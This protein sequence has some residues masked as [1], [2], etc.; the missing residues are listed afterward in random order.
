MNA[1]RKLVD[2]CNQHPAQLLRLISH[3]HGANV[4]NLATGMGLQTCTLI[5]LSPPVHD[6]YMPDIARVTSRTFFSIHPTIDLVG[7]ELL[8]SS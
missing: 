2:W 7:L 3:S 1:A 4:A 6:R 8:I 5:H